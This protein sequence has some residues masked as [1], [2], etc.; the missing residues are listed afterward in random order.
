MPG[1]NNALTKPQSPRVSLSGKWTMP[2][3]PTERVP[4]PGS[5][6][7]S[8][9]VGQS[10]PHKKSVPSSSFGREKRLAPEVSTAGGDVS[11]S[12]GRSPR[13]T[14]LECNRVNPGPGHYA[15]SSGVGRQSLSTRG[16]SPTTTLSPRLRDISRTADVLGPG[17]CREDGFLSPR[18][19]Y[20]STAR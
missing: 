4:G 9:G 1:P 16:T 13:G 6:S 10:G 11:S 20:T 12:G 3:K 8:G 18:T 19:R 15:I 17:V 14:L 2:E 7:V 5:Y